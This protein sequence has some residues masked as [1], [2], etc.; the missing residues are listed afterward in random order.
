MRA[1]P[2]CGHRGG[3][4]LSLITGGVGSDRFANSLGSEIAP[5]PKPRRNHPNRAESVLAEI[6]SSPL[7]EPNQHFAVT[8]KRPPL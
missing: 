8:L 7:S 6:A 1:S 5:L 4:V 2:L 3:A